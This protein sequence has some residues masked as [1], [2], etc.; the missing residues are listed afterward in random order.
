LTSRGNN[1]FYEKYKHL[2]NK[3]IGEI[4]M[5][6]FGVPKHYIEEILL[7]LKKSKE[8]KTFGELAIQ[9]GLINEELVYKALAIQHEMDF[10]SK[11]EA[12]TLFNFKLYQKEE[13]YSSYENEKKFVEQ[14][15]TFKC[16]PAYVDFKEDENHIVLYFAQ[17][18]LNVSN[19]AFETFKARIEHHFNKYTDEE[20]KRL[21]EKYLN[22]INGLSSKEQSKIKIPITKVA[23]CLTPPSV[24]ERFEQIYKGI[25]KEELI[26]YSKKIDIDITDEQTF[27]QLT[28]LET[29]INGE[30]RES[31]SSEENRGFGSFGNF[32]FGQKKEESQNMKKRDVRINPK[33]YLKMLLTYAIINDVSDIHIEPN[34][35]S[36]YRISMRMRGER[37]TIDFF[38]AQMATYLINIIKS[39]ANISTQAIHKPQDG[40]IDGSSFLKKYKLPLIREAMEPVFSFPKVSFRVS[41]YPVGKPIG[42]AEDNVLYESVVIRVLGASGSSVEL[43]SLG[44]S[45]QSEK[46]LRYATKRNQGIVLITGPTGSGKSTTLYSTLSLIDAIKKKIITF[47]DPIERRNMYWAQAERKI[48]SNDDT[49]FDFSDAK[50][51]ILRQ[52]PNVIL[53]GEVRDP[54]SA[55]FAV[56]AANTGHLVFTTIHANSAADAFERLAEL[57]VLPVKIATSALAVFAQ[58]LVRRVCPNCLIRRPITEEEKEMIKRLEIFSND[59]I[60]EEVVDANPNGCSVC[61]YTGYIGR[62]LIDEVIPVTQKVREMI[63]QELPSFEIRKEVSKMGYK[64]MVQNGMDKMLK[65]ETT[66]KDILE[67]I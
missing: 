12:T 26:N 56:E 25:T 52:D 65:G 16:F 13:I 41:T 27:E 42:G 14:L 63:A 53:M 59:E 4:L 17:T 58:R 8:R 46:E 45:E 51:A 31:Y 1:K 9:L 60:P 22:Q 64:A 62:T 55:Q 66:L 33:M 49:T 43:S 29:E 32:G 48:T 36:Q 54:E 2:K 15:K 30:N 18:N 19:Y 40:S 34:I 39:T 37:V 38:D 5:E 21:K 6:V 61:N 20:A 23:F 3:K 24:Y 50:K 47:E 44:I 10:K 28:F 11:I 57:K 35:G 7:K 67:V